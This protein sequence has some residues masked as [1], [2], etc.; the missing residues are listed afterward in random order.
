M[1]DLLS[2]TKVRSA[3]AIL[4]I[5]F[6]CSVAHNISFAAGSSPK[7]GFDQAL[8][9]ETNKRIDIPYNDSTKIAG[10]SDFTVSMWIYPEGTEGCKTLFRQHGYD[11][12]SFGP[13]LRYDSDESDDN[14]YLYVMFNKMGT[15]WQHS[16]PWGSTLPSD[17]IRIPL[18]QWSHVALTKSDHSVKTYINGVLGHVFTLDSLRFNAPASS[19]GVISVG[20]DTIE[21][22]YFDGPIDEVQYWNTA[23]SQD[24]INNWMYR[25]IDHTHPEY[26]NLVYYYKLNHTTGTA[27]T[28]SKGTYHGTAVNISDGNWVESGIRRWAC[29][30]G[31]SVSGKLVGS[32]SDGS[33]TN[34]ANWNLSFIITQQ[35][36]KGT[37]TI[38]SGNTFTYQSSNFKDEGTDFFKYKVRD[39][40]GNESAE[41]TVYIDLIPA[42]VISGNAGVAGAELCYQEKTAEGGTRMVTADETGAYSFKVPYNWSGTVTPRKPGYLF[43]PAN[44]SYTNVLADQTGKDYTTTVTYTIAPVSDQSMTALIE[45]YGAGEKE[46]ITIPVKKT[47]AG[48]LVSLYT[49]LSGADAD[50]FEMTQPIAAELD[51]GTPSTTFTIKAKNGL[52]EGTYTATVTI[53]ATNLSDKTFTVTQKVYPA[54]VGDLSGQNLNYVDLNNWSSHRDGNWVVEPGGRTVRQTINGQAGFYLS[55]DNYINKVITG[56]I[57]VNTG[58]DDDMIGFVSGFHELT[59]DDGNG[60]YYYDFILFDWK[61]E[62]QTG[63][64]D[65]FNK[66]AEEGYTL[67]RVTGEMNMTEFYGGLGPW[68]KYFWFHAPEEGKF[69]V[70][71]TKYGAGNKWVDFQ[72]YSFKIL[73]TRDRIKILIDDE[74]IFDISEPNGFKEGM[75]GFYNSSQEQV[76]YG[77]VQSVD[78]IPGSTRPIAQEDRYGASKNTELEVDRFSGILFNDYDPNLDLFNIV[79][80]DGPTKGTL[81]LLE[82]GAFNYTP[83]ADVTGTDSFTYKLVETKEGG[84]ESD[85]VTVEINIIDGENQAPS[86]ITIT[87]TLLGETWPNGTIVG[88]L[89]T[90]DENEGDF[91]DLMLTNNAGGRFGITGNQIVVN[92]S[93]LINYG[94]VHTIRVRSTDFR[95]ASIEKDFYIEAPNKVVFKNY[96]GDILKTEYV[97]DGNSASPPELP[98]RS[99]Y[100]FTGWDEDISVITDNLN[101]TAQYA[102]NTGT[103]YKVEH[104]RQTVDGSSYIKFETETLTGTTD[105]LAN[106]VPKAY[107]GFSENTSHGS[108]VPSGIIV[109]DGS[110]VLKLYY[111]RNTYTVSFNTNDGSDID[112]ITGIRYENKISAPAEPTKE[113]Y[114]FS[115][116]YK[117]AGF[118]NL[119]DFNEDKVMA[120]TTL[121]AKWI[122]ITYTIEDIENQTMDVLDG[123]YAAG[124]Q[125]T[126]TITITRT[127]NGDLHNLAV[128]LSG[129][130][131]DSFIITQPADITLDDDTTSTVFTIKAKDGLAAGTYTVTV[132]ISATNMTNVNFTVSQI[133]KPLAPIGVTAFRGDT[134]VTLQWNSVTGAT[135]YKIYYGTISGVYELA[136]V[137]DDAFAT[138]Y[139]IT[140]LTN[141]TIYYF[142][143][144]AYNLGGDSPASVE[145]SETPQVPA[146]G[147]L[148][149]VT[150]TKGDTKVTLQWNS[151]TGATGYKIYYGTISGVYELANVLDDVFATSYEITGLT[152]GTTYYFIIKATNPGGDSPASVEVSA[153]PQVPAP[154]APILQSAISGDG[155][156]LLNWDSAEGATGYKVFQ[157]ITSGSYGA[158]IDLVSNTTT[159]Y[160]A[161]GLTNGTTY[162]FV[163]KATNPGGDSP[164]SNEVSATPQVPAPGA[165]ILQSAI[166]GDGHV[167]LNWDSA[168]GATGYKVF[169]SITSGSYGA[170]IDLVSS[171]TTTYDAIGLTNGTAYYFIVKATNPGGDSPV[172]NEVS[173]TPQVPAPGAPMILSAESGNGYVSITWASVD[174]A[175]GYKVF[176]STTSGTYGAETDIVAS[177]TT[178]YDAIGLTNGTTYY[179]AVKATN[180]GG[181]SPASN[182][183]STV[184]RS[185]PGAPFDVTARAGD[186]KAIVRFTAPTDDGGSPITGYIVTSDPDNITAMGTDTTITVTGLTNRV[187][188]TFTVQAINAVGYSIDSAASN[189]V[190]PYTRSDSGDPGEAATDEQASQTPEQGMELLVNGDPI[191]AATTSTSTIDDHTVTTVTINDEIIE[192]RL[193]QEGNNAVVT[194]PVTDAADDIV[195]QLNGQMVKNMEN[196][197]ATLEIKTENVTYSIPASQINVDNV[198]NQIGGQAELKDIIVNIRISLPL[199]DIAEVVEDVADKN[200]YSIIVKPISFEITCTSGDNTIDVTKFNA[201]VERLMEIPE[202]IDP[203]K[204][205]TGIVLNDD[206]TFTHVPTVITVIEG[207]Y[208]AR[209]NS[210]TNSTYTV[211][212]NPVEFADVAAH[213]V[214]DIANDMGSRLIIDGVGNNNFEP[215][216]EI[217]RGEFAEIVVRALGLLRAGIGKD[218]FTDVTKDKSY[219]DAISI[220]NEYELIFGYGN[221]IFGYSDKI[222]REQAVAIIARAHRLTEL[223]IELSTEE[224]DELLAQFVDAGELEDYTKNDMALCIKS[225]IVIG[226]GNNKIAPK[227]YLT[228]AEA[229]T[230]VRQLLKKSKLI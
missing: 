225:E 68:S 102:A 174:G 92:N 105:T 73:Y 20:G 117:E 93:S 123:N 26:D 184:P 116:W 183:V 74:V 14:G 64:I 214:K 182:E 125:E 213:W 2:K 189:A 126:K 5:L 193:E 173:A 171:T 163:I 118:I 145:V 8:D 141:G 77:N 43:T 29:N 101:I 227:E 83:D 90:I 69:D 99:G 25:E 30:A 47:G 27:V 110:L 4:L 18:N 114:I 34:G 150:A 96:N 9:F 6:F 61:Q 45:G 228:R 40:E 196:K 28:D 140:G 201:Y 81:N 72:E 177:T 215:D 166:S 35:G 142:I 21:G 130:N 209:I 212:Y 224:A 19:S 13:W 7:A 210:L 161:I 199:Q 59:D 76:I 155:H 188:Y 97:A 176:Q 39:P 206:G 121:Y 44:R 138:S 170:E 192:E 120:D 104:Y 15:S 165:P 200:N 106:A 16:W 152:N 56:T 226:R 80:V 181:D 55:P 148:T 95:G 87:N 179:F 94:E 46:T 160:D 230:L 216:T 1:K 54:D 185:V 124:T 71:D 37:A 229:A 164:V 98:E 217:S 191:I 3:I 190:I 198:F 136:N 36:S 53:S 115:G 12:G 222:T 175:T 180:P 197:D 159:T 113:G 51:D 127:G 67:A 38:T 103:Q 223:E 131:S 186:R 143:V 147:A 157:S 205:T 134:K 32:D 62:R 144:K 219:Y 91:H 195:S 79:I 218:T 207:K 137:L 48:D 85:T 178:T 133:V 41:A 156:V 162:Y 149:G 17:V 139:E 202:G 128:A 10:N 168:E 158:E 204:I 132:T 221:G 24:E 208:Y 187:T 111:D 57:K 88:T 75:F 203:G 89:S 23:L 33:S 50:A 60:D 167:L 52:T 172:S 49:E 109:G 86:D 31:A 42:K 169:Q 154:G 220:A 58:N 112:D 100:T 122:L 135:G 108:R 66:V 22:N 63:Y 65:V 107:D 84:E 153:T 129:E 151:V 211:I 119:W 146:P 82:Q 11:S 78:I 194:I 70:L